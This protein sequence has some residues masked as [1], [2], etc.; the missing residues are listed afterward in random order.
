MK[1]LEN[2]TD[3]D[4]CDDISDMMQRQICIDRIVQNQI[5]KS[6]NPRICKD[7]DMMSRKSCLQQVAQEQALSSGDTKVCDTL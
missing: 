7:M 6:P 5:Q 3:T 1:K 4:D 2:S